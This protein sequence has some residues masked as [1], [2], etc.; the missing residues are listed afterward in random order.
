VEEEASIMVHS[1]PAIAGL[2]ASILLLSA[3]VVAPPPAARAASTLTVTTTADLS[4]PCTSAAFSLRCAI[5]QANADADGDTINFNIPAT[6]AGCTGTPVVCTIKPTSALPPLTA[7][8]TVI[9][10]Y[11]QP[12]ASSNTNQLSAGDNAV[13]TLRLDGSAA[14]AG[15]DGLD[16]SGSSDTVEGLS[17]TGFQQ[18]TTPTGTILGGEGVN[19]TGGTGDLVQGSFLGVALDGTTAAANQLG[20]V[21]VNNGGK[22]TVGGTT[23]ALF[24]VISGNG[25]CS[26]GDCVGFAVYVNSGSGTLVQGNAIGTTARGTAKLANLATGIVVLANNTTLGGTAT[27]AGNVISGNGGDGVLVGSTGNSIAGNKIGTNAS[28]TAGL[29]NHSH[30]LDIQ[31]SSNTIVNN[32][33][34]SN[35]DTGVVLLGSGNT[36]Q[37]NRVGTNR[38][39]TAALGN[40]F[41]P[42]GNLFGQLING[43]DGIVVCV[44]PNTIGGTRTG[45]GNLVSGNAGDGISLVSSG[46]LIQGNT[47]GANA[48]GTAALPNGV[49]GIGSKS[50]AFK[51]TGFCQQGLQ[52]GGNSNTISGNLVSGNTGVGVDLVMSN[53]NLL[54]G[55]KIGINTAG[56]FAIPNG[57]DG[58][59]IAGS[60]TGSTCHGSSNNTI[61]GVTSGTGN[62]VSGNTGNGIT[63][64]GTGA[65]TSN[66]VQGNHIGTDPGGTVAIGNRANGVQLMHS[67]VNDS[68]GG[69]AAGTGNTIANNSQSGVLVGAS[70]GDSG[71][72][73]PVQENA[74]VSNGGLGIDL[75]PQGTI[76]C[77]T[78]PPG[79]NDYTACPVIQ[80]ASPAQV[81]GT[82]CASCTVE[83]YVATGEADDQNHGEGK[84]FL[85]S[86]TAG[87]GGAW[88][89]VLAAGTVSSGQLVTATATTPASFATSAETSEFAA[90]KTVS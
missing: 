70:S 59:I 23:P 31:G 37:G 30:G 80:S 66:A 7:G 15:A 77:A 32:V 43:T 19:F 79:P 8:T 38:A 22:D 57:A 10:G 54:T 1:R 90:N 9:N 74:I 39:G 53:S 73:S 76:N 75:A 44:G 89:L 24:N 86:T 52:T 47:V 42:S 13:L 51:G 49:D 62:T 36:M 88:S 33:V 3:M 81:S 56:T 69:T 28:G 16:I 41:T 35:G 67:A 18:K 20:G 50:D 17:I 4:S 82:A 34:S 29:G 48:A 21:G 12:G 87:A 26:F 45:S 83:V 14:G 6:A 72:H 60:C 40:G 27:G 5:I 65:G 25:S 64:D 55:N 11:S 71:T 85:G 46:N 61:G 2:T 68:V 63:I 84:V 58:I 78:N